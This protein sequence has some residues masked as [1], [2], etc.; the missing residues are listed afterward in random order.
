MLR[1]IIDFGGK[2]FGFLPVS[3]LEKKEAME[4]CHLVLRISS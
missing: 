1:W 2:T 3:F 4:Q